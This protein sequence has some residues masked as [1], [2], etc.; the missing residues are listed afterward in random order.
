MVEGV[1]ECGRDGG[2]AVLWDNGSEKEW[3]ER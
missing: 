2:V 3:R 1:K